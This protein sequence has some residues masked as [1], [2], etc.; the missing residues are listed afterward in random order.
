[1]NQ[2]N[3]FVILNVNVIKRNTYNTTFLREKLQFYI[4]VSPNNQHHCTQ[5]IGNYFHSRRRKQRSVWVC[6][7]CPVWHI[8]VIEF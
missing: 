1:M 5:S 3:S 6:V 4:F 2:F 7:M 8:Y